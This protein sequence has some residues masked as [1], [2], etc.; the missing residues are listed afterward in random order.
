[1]VDRPRSLVPRPPLLGALLLAACSKPEPVDTTPLIAVTDG[2]APAHAAEPPLLEKVAHI[3]ASEHGKA[4]HDVATRI[5]RDGTYYMLVSEQ[6]GAPVS[7]R[8]QQLTTVRRDGIERLEALFARVCTAPDTVHPS[9]LARVRYRVV[10]PG[11]TRTFVNGVPSN[12]SPILE[13]ESIVDASMT[14][15]PRAP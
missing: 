15:I 5:H 10:S 12:E 4:G 14:P 9:D 3:P 2:L 8:W 6:A 1:M 7:P 11:C 13:A